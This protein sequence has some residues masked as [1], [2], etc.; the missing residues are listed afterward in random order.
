MGILEFGRFRDVEEFGSVFR[1]RGRK[2][3]REVALCILAVDGHLNRL[4]TR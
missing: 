3:H 1:N 4:I 2:L